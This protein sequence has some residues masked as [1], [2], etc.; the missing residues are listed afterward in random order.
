MFSGIDVLRLGGIKGHVHTHGHTGLDDSEQ[1]MLSVNQR[2]IGGDGDTLMRSIPMSFSHVLRHLF[3]FGDVHVPIV[4]VPLKP[5]CC[6]F[7][8]DFVAIPRSLTEIIASHL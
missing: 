4:I 7:G 3:D 1:P 5:F 8:R 2:A 6:L